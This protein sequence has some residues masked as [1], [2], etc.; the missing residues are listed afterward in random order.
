M[1]GGVED[2]I[3]R[4][5]IVPFTP[6]PPHT[7]PPR[8]QDVSGCQRCVSECLNL[9]QFCHRGVTDMSRAVTEMSPIGH[10]LV[11][12]CHGDVAAC[13]TEISHTSRHDRDVL[14][15]PCCVLQYFAKLRFGADHKHYHTNTCHKIVTEMSRDCHAMSPVVTDVSRHVT[16]MS[17]PSHIF[18]TSCHKVSQRPSH[19]SHRVTECQ[20]I[21]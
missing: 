16:K 18:V 19:Q 13:H 1:S 6:R 14:Y 2:C 9:L 15:S 5:R 8:S 21:C 4:Y 11:T 10:K 20:N 17:R 7:T 3:Y 12:R